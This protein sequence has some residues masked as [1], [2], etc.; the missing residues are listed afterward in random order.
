MWITI[1]IETAAPLKIV[2][3]RCTSKLSAIAQN[4]QSSFAAIIPEL[5]ANSVTPNGPPLIVYHDVIDTEA[6]GDIEVCVPIDTNFE[7]SSTA[8]T[9]RTLEGGKVAKTIHTG[10]Y[11]EI[12]P[13][14]QAITS[15]IV[16]QGYEVAGPPREIYLNDPQQVAQTELQTAVEFPVTK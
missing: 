5:Q 2:S 1:N 15:W 12:G 16:G 4:I 9:I 10:P 13:A 8:I 14:Y 7:P 6:H 11:Q 3:V